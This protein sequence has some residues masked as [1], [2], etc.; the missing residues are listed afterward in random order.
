M[1]AAEHE[2]NIEEITQRAD[3]AEAAL[4]RSR[5]EVK[6]A[7]EDLATLV[8]QKGK[9]QIENVELE[10]VVTTLREEKEV[11]GTGYRV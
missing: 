4:A 5:E 2:M 6:N 9:L 8:E 10:E 3:V 1:D 11:Q 7:T